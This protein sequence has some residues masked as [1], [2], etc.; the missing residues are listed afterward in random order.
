MQAL[1]HLSPVELRTM[2]T[3]VESSLYFAP[4]D[5]LYRQVAGKDRLGQ[6]ASAELVAERIVAAIEAPEPSLRWPAGE[7]AELVLAARDESDDARWER[8]VRRTMDL[9]W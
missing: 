9:T 4:Y 6:G 2:G 5:E 3:V 1:T 7:D 8:L